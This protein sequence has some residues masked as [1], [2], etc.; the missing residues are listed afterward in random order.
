MSP[1]QARGAPDVDHR[2]D[3]YALGV[4]LFECLAGCPPFD[5]PSD[6]G[7]INQHAVA[8][9][10][11]I[12]KLNPELP[13][14]L[15]PMLCKALAKRPEDRFQ[16]AGEFLAALEAA[17]DPPVESPS[18]EPVQAPA[19]PE[20]DYQPYEAARSV[21]AP[22][23]EP[24]M[25]SSVLEPQLQPA[26]P[27]PRRQWVWP[28][29]ALGAVLMAGGVHLF[30]R[31]SGR[32][33]LP[34]PGERVAAP[35]VPVQPMNLPPDAAL[36]AAPSEAGG[37]EDVAIAVPVKPVA[38]L[39]A[40]KVTSVLSGKPYPA[41]VEVDGEDSGDTPATLELPVGKHTVRVQ[42]AGFQTVDTHVV[43]K[44]RQTA[45]VSVDLIP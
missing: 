42:R 13:A 31:G 26:P 9:P 16:S 3:L 11:E 29:I 38:Q 45:S 6:L 4:L 19:E 10:P 44:P 2:A 22:A 21:P 34:E 39:G 40:L 24:G 17:L 25:S 41:S 5:S 28:V 30:L 18:V 14:A 36:V 43:I 37:A 32:A 1:E 27:I 33:A 20:I 15:S 7:I 35:I 12:N 8:A 23:P